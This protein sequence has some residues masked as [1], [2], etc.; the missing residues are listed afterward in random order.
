MQTNKQKMTTQYVPF[1]DGFARGTL[2]RK[3]YLTDIRDKWEDSESIFKKVV[4]ET[5]L[6]IKYMCL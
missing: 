5:N 2:G 1:C 6:N 4:A 3:V